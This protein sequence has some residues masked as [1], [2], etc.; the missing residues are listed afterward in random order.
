MVCSLEVC[1]EYYREYLVSHPTRH[2]LS[3]NNNMHV[4]ADKIVQINPHSLGIFLRNREYL[5]MA[6]Y[7]I[8]MILRSKRLMVQDA[9][10]LP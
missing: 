10:Q 8:L 3:F 7:S 9:S 5:Y 2:T 4:T 1:K 6:G